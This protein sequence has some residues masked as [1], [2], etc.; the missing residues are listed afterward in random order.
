MEC[1]CDLEWLFTDANRLLATHVFGGQCS[2][3]T[4][5]DRL[6]HDYFNFCHQGG[7]AI[8]FRSQTSVINYILLS[9][10]VII[11]QYFL[12]LMGM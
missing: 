12:C 8:T 11:I 2:D 7:S 1:G 3:G 9:F 4:A 5:F 10:F 6:S